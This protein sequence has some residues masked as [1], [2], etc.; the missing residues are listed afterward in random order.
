MPVFF[1]KF[2]KKSSNIFH[3]LF[4]SYTGNQLR[5]KTLFSAVLFCNTK[6]TATFLYFRYSCFSKEI[7]II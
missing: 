6:L 1:V 5:D 4:I 2:P 7:V 3:A